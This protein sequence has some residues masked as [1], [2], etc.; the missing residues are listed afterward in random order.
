MW[1]LGALF[2]C[3]LICTVIV[4]TC[5]VIN[6]TVS[7]IVVGFTNHYKSILFCIAGTDQI[8]L[9]HGIKRNSYVA[10]V[11]FK[12]VLLYRCPKIGSLLKNCELFHSPN[13]PSTLGGWR[14]CCVVAEVSF[15]RLWPGSQRPCCSQPRTRQTR[16]N[17]FSKF[18]PSS[19]KLEVIKDK[20]RHQYLAERPASASSELRVW[21]SPAW[22][23]RGKLGNVG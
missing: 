18:L 12:M 19:Q 2:W 1:S 15:V 23:V 20:C 13:Q 21:P 16:S 3:P 17:G 9:K 7:A 10:S 5:K 6:I 22:T 14:Y 4:R 8:S 11:M